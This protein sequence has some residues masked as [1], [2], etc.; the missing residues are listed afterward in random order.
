MTSGEHSVRGGG[1]GSASSDRAGAARAPLLREL[2]AGKRLP[3]S[4][5]KRTALPPLPGPRALWPRRVPAALGWFRGWG[6]A[7]DAVS[8]DSPG[9]G[10][11][12]GGYWINDTPRDAS[13]PTQFY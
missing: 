7:R 5:E 2:V 9:S 1:C 10:Q 12:F 8:A 3:R 6:R 13:L 11:L 4:S